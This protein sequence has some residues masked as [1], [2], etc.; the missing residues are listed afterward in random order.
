VKSVKEQKLI[1]GLKR[2]AG[3]IRTDSSEFQL[4]PWAVRMYIQGER[5]INECQRILLLRELIVAWFLCP[6]VPFTSQQLG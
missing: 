3:F 2:P 5:M 1:Q 6:D 4:Y